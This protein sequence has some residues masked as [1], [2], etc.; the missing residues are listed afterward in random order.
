MLRD[1]LASFGGKEW[2]IPTGQ[3]IDKFMRESMLKETNMIPQ[4]M[5][6]ASWPPY[7]LTGA[8]KRSRHAHGFCIGL[9]GWKMPPC[10]GN[11][12]RGHQD[13]QET[14]PRS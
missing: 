12:I 14:G 7:H 9:A 13:L 6:G 3:A 11:T 10:G 8:E 4:T 1:N 2:K 5:H